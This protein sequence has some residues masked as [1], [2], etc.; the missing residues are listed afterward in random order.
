[1]PEFQDGFVTLLSSDLSATGT[2]TCTGTG[3]GVGGVQG[4]VLVLDVRTVRVEGGRREVFAGH[5][6]PCLLVCVC[7]LQWCVCSH[8]K[9]ILLP[10][11][12]CLF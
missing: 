3:S 8:N 10:N 4:L 6:Y 1:M 5:I 11:S 9:L 12:Y 7:L 2:G